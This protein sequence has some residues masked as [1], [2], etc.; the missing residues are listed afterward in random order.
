MP[1]YFKYKTPITINFGAV[2]AVLTTSVRKN[3]VV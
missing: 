2:A 1:D 3:T